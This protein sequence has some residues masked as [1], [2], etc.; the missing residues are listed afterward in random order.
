MSNK[1]R[2]ID[3]EAL[4]DAIEISKD[5]SFV[6]VYINS[7]QPGLSGSVQQEFIETFSDL[8]QNP[9]Y[10]DPSVFH[11]GDHPRGSDWRTW[12]NKYA[13]HFH[14]MG[15]K[16]KIIEALLERADLSKKLREKLNES[17]EV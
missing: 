6:T 10:H 17:S 3:Q 15:D 13:C 11:V 9:S 7:D 2:F 8:L 16:A 12:E 5:D 1:I 4:I 14:F